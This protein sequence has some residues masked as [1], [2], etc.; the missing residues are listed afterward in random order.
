MCRFFTI[1]ILTQREVLLFFLAANFLYIFPL[2]QADYFYNDDNWR[3][4]ATGENWSEEGRVVIEIFYNLISF[5]STAPDLFPLPLFI[6]VVGISLSLRALTFFYF[7]RPSVVQCLVVLPIWYNPYFLQNLT[8]RYDG[9]VMA[10]GMAALIYALIWPSDRVWRHVWGPGLLIGLALSIYQVFIG[11]FIALCCL[12]VIRLVWERKSSVWVLNF[13]A[14]KFL[15]IGIGVLVYYL[16]AHQLMSGS[17]QVL[18]PMEVNSLLEIRDRLL[19]LQQMFDAGGTGGLRP[20]AWG[21]VVLALVGYVWAGVRL[22]LCPEQRWLKMLLLVFYVLSIPVLLFCIPGVTLLFA[23][24]NG[25]ART[26]VAF[27]VLLVLIFFLCLRVLVCIHQRLGFFLFVPVL[28]MLSFSFSYGRILLLQKEQESAVLASLVY[29]IT[30]S[31]LY[32]KNHI[33][34]IPELSANWLPAAS[35]AFAAM[36]V[37]KQVLGVDYVLMLGPLRRGGI[38]DVYLARDRQVIASIRRGDH[39]SVMSTLFYDLYVIADSGYIF[40]KK[41]EGNPY[42][43]S[44]LCLI[45]DIE[46]CR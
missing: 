42:A 28:A 40:M 43:I 21:A 39:P 41:V 22:L 5:G 25:G 8:Y 46:R 20:L 9:P 33:Y 31:S 14:R 27:S 45:A 24:F 19:S 3:T 38:A 4:F 36:P 15:A 1:K 12:E 29:D 26:F 11:F 2:V 18:L 16:T 17:R 44:E 6:A 7:Q 23:E 10:L 30:H 35:A 32:E 37:L 13:V 34:L